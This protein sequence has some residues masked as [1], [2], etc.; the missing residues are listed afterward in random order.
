MKL[1]AIIAA[2]VF[3]SSAALADTVT[4][5]S[6]PLSGTSDNGID[7]YRGVPYAAP[8]VGALRWEPPAAPAKWTTPRD[9]SRFGAICPQRGALVEDALAD[10]RVI[11]PL[12]PLPQSED[13]LVLN[14]NSERWQRVLSPKLN[15]AWNLHTQTLHTPLDCFVLF[16]TMSCV[17]GMAGQAN[18]AA[19]NTFLDA[20]AHEI[21]ICPGDF[22]AEADVIGD[23]HV[24][25]QSVLLE[26]HTDITL[27]G[28]QHGDVFACQ[29]NPTI[30][31]A[32]E[33]GDHAQ[34]GRFATAAGAE[35]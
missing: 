17:F 19:A 20:L 32:L 5:D 34:H 4:I 2:L 9:A 27:V 10:N 24:G 33:T 6:G 21:R 23:G 30:S 22:H 25:E 1:A 35:K 16:S 28:V 3:A 12:P 7:V 14:L 11:G 13:C 29:H 15:G 31:R 26:D 8:P 18:Y